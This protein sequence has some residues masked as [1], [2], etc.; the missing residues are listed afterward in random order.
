[1]PIASVTNLVRAAGQLKEDGYSLVGADPA[2]SSDCGDVAFAFPLALV[3]GGEARGI[4][5]LLR[6]TCDTLV[7]IPMEGQVESLNASAAATAF[8][9]EAARQRRKQNQE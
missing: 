2:G 1:L 7:R 5:P 6:K 8:F 9:F 4:R 3:L